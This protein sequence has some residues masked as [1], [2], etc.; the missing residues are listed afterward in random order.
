[1]NRR[2]V[3]RGP[4]DE[5]VFESDAVVLGMRRLSIIDLGGGHQPLSTPDQSCWIIINGE[6]Y[7]FRALRDELER[8]GHAFRTRSDTEVALHA[9]LEWGDAFLSRLLGMFC[10]AI[11]DGRKG[12]AIVARDRVG[13][14]P[15]YYHEDAS[16]R[17]VF[18][19]E[20]KCLLA[21]P[22]V[23]TTLSTDACWQYLRLGYIP[24]AG[25]ILQSVRRLPP[26]HVL[27]QERG[28][29]AA[30]RA[31]WTPPAADPQAG[32]KRWPTADA[33]AEEFLPLLADATSSR[34]VA[35]V[36]VGAFLSGGIDSST[37]VALM[38]RAHSGK[39][40]TFSVG[41]PMAGR[42]DESGHAAL[43]A[44]ELGTDH[45]PFHVG[46][47]TLEELPRLAWQLDEPLGDQ[48]AL[49]TMLLSRLARAH[50][51]VV[52]TGEGAD[53]VF[54]GYERYRMLSALER[55]KST[56][57]AWPLRLAG[58][59]LPG[60]E[61]SF[62]RMARI[63]AALRRADQPLSAEY[64]A[65]V[66]PF[67]PAWLSE[68]TGPALQGAAPPSDPLAPWLDGNGA[69]PLARMQAADLATWLPDDLLAKVDR[70]TMAASLEARCP[71]LDHRVIELGALLP[72]EWKIAQGTTKWLLRRLARSI[73]P[74]SVLQRPKQIFAMP[75][76]DWLRGPLAGMAG[77][78]LAPARL[79]RHG[80]FECGAGH[81]LL[82]LHRSGEA[83][84][85]R[86]LWAMLMFQLWHDGLEA[87]VA[88]AA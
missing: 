81:R 15:L 36:P 76:A 70:T 19:S 75:L 4:D 55:A 72:D 62:D 69:S 21:D 73:L 86:P 13:K 43:V 34:L 83:D 41:F 33:A 2:M 52:L 44:A 74:P 57:G 29:K 54:G 30:I 63:R 51:T 27:T 8:A 88:A 47:E 53:E 11:W 50:V 64:G 3:H 80:V 22:G 37:V 85:A 16:G 39:V 48:A 42:L 10:L 84:L 9:Y 40:R 46:P 77:D 68:V 61:R 59:L 12:R 23:A 65:L 18:A 60:R 66:A 32:R 38:A 45:T 24:G 7:N 14:K 31:W 26:G 5:G 58:Q 25:T 79:E 20:L 35:D 49:P 67:G 1:M 87:D 28:A 71:F 82:A 17:V 56:V 78:T 6:I